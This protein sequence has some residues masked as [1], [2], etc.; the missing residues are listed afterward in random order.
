[1]AIFKNILLVYNFVT[2][3]KHSYDVA[4]EIAKKFDSNITLLMCIH[5]EPTTFTF[6][7]TKKEKRKKET[8]IEKSKEFLDLLEKE[9]KADGIFLK[10][11]F[12]V[13]EKV[14]ESTVDFVV[15]NDVDLLI[16]DSP[17]LDKIE[18]EDHKETVNK[19]YK[20]VT[21]P[22]LTLK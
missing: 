6:F 3:T 5:D 11:E 10:I 22:I 4:M 21:C 18:H 14:M 19:I 12:L 13:T 16:I 20:S 1:M 17:Q 7:S 2:E 9:A 15:K 8:Q